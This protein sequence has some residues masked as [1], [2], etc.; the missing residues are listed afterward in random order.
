MFWYYSTS[1]LIQ[2][3]VGGWGDQDEAVIWINV[4][5]I[6]LKEKKKPLNTDEWEI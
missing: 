6:V 2:I 3:N 1:S 5:K 4:A